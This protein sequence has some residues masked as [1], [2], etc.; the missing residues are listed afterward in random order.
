[1]RSLACCLVAGLCLAGCGLVD[2]SYG[3]LGARSINGIDA[4]V[5]LLKDVGDVESA[6]HVSE[7]V[8]RKADILVHFDNGRRNDAHYFRSVEAWL[9][10]LPLPHR[11]G[12]KKKPKSE[13]SKRGGRADTVDAK[14]GDDEEAP[15][16]VVPP[17]ART[18][19]YVAFDTTASVDFWRRLSR[20]MKGHAHEQSWC[21]AQ[22]EVRLR[23][24]ELGPSTPVLF[25][26]RSLRY[27]RGRSFPVQGELAASRLQWPVRQVPS[28]VRTA[29][30]GR[31]PSRESLL[32]S[33]RVPLV[34]VVRAPAARLVLVYNGAPLLNYSLVRAP[35][36]SFARN[37]VASLPPEGLKGRPNIV[38]VT[39]NLLPTVAAARADNPLKILTT[40]PI[41]LILVHLLALLFLF[42]LAR[43]PHEETPLDVAPRG[44]RSFLEHIEALG[45]RLARTRR[46]HVV[47]RGIERLFARQR[48]FHGHAEKAREGEPRSRVSNSDL[49]KEAAQYWENPK[50]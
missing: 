43:W 9:Q 45:S 38:L 8:L 36:R 19:L 3:T 50:E 10:K 44:S 28:P 5:A 7:R 18:L 48:R 17:R 34:R 32:T 21:L 16:F 39:G 40:F 11:E 47:V 27:R 37:L 6:A 23:A 31:L 46:R 1:M 35:Q 33:G 12:R 42:L 29:T 4:F 2:E 30:G 26:G 49:M 41:S 15:P 25:G 20:Q 13:S 24:R 14:S 22:M